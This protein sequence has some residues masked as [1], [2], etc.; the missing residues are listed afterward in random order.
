MNDVTISHFAEDHGVIRATN[1]SH[2]VKIRT[3][4]IIS[5]YVPLVSIYKTVLH[6]F[7]NGC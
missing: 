1:N 6:F 7:F 5:L 2:H 3:T 4:R